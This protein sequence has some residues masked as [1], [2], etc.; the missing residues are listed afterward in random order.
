MFSPS[1]ESIKYT[2]RTLE[3]I[4]SNLNRAAKLIEKNIIS[5]INSIK[6]LDDY[7]DNCVLKKSLY[8]LILDKFSWKDSPK[9]TK[10]E[11]RIG[12]F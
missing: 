9:I 2:E 5:K 3:Y 10:F 1:R 12:Y 7:F 4:I 6:S 8:N 11:K